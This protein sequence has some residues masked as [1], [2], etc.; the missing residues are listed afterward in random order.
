MLIVQLNGSLL[1]NCFYQLR[2][3]ATDI[4]NR[5]VTQI[6]VEVNTATKPIYL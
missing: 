4:S 3:R 1:E 6:V 2:L 5:T